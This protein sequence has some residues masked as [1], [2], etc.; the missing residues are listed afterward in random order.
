MNFK[1]VLD[2]VMSFSVISACAVI[3]AIGVIQ[4]SNRPQKP[5]MPKVGDKM[6]LVG[7][8]IGNKTLV[9]AVSQVCSFCEKSYP[10]YRALQEKAD[11]RLIVAREP[12]DYF[13]ER[14]F[15]KNTVYIADFKKLNISGTPTLVLLDSSGKIQ[16][17][18]QGFL[19]L[20]KE[21]EV[22]AA[23]N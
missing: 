20:E 13:Y 10:F 4:I 8:P 19:S 12:L 23:L 7:V 21:K 22:F 14:G 1:K 2:Y 6:D 11:F 3:V 18:W 15:A 5:V 9:A 16:K 17:V